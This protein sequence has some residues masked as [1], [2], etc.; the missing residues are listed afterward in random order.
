MAYID[1]IRRKNLRTLIDENGGS[2][3]AFANLVDI[4]YA[5]IYQWVEGAPD[6]KTGKPRGMRPASCRKI[7]I[8][9][10]KPEG[11]LDQDHSKESVD[12]NVEAAP[13]IKGRIPLISWVQAGA[14]AEAIDTFQPGDAE[15]WLPTVT[16]MSA[17]SFALRVKGIS[18]EPKF[19]DGDIIYVD[20]E[21]A[22]DSGK[23]VIVRLDDE[24]EVTFKQLVIEDGRKYLRPLN[25]A[26]EPQLIKIN[27]NATICGVV[28]SKMVTF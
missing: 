6:A 23:Y 24:Q 12:T 8:G 5:Q 15:E 19:Q 4:A 17:S 13:D 9:A 14:F 28:V 1:E 27:G 20:P 21:V 7:E 2:P 26:W 16:K 18:M 25:P 3:T 22:A 10:G 11:W